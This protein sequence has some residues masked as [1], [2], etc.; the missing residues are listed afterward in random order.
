MISLNRLFGFDKISFIW[1]KD[2]YVFLLKKTAFWFLSLFRIFFFYPDRS[3]FKII[4]HNTNVNLKLLLVAVQLF[5][6]FD[7]E[8]NGNVV[9][10]V[11][12]VF[13]KNSFTS[14]S[15][16]SFFTNHHST[17]FREQISIKNLLLK[18]IVSFFNPRKLLRTHQTVSILL[19]G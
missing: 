11:I 2:I 8:N 4:D 13:I 14:L 9:F 3:G 10:L 7:F 19:F 12:H 6:S 18:N 15:S 17:V 16:Y 1:Q 5:Q